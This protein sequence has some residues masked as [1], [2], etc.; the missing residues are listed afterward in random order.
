MACIGTSV[1]VETIDTQWI[2]FK[3]FGVGQSGPTRGLP[4]DLFTKLYIPSDY[5]NVLYAGDEIC[6]QLYKDDTANS[7]LW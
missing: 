3:Y 7:N 6:R 1:K 4:L 2:T 5:L